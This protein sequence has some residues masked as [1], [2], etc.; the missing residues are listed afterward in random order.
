MGGLSLNRGGQAPEQMGLERSLEGR[1]ALFQVEVGRHAGQRACRE[2]GRTS[3]AG[4]FSL[5]PKTW[6]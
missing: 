1:K 6:R 3:G 4:H 5:R 2:D